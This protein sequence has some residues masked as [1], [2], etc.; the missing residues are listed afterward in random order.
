MK[1]IRAIIYPS[2]LTDEEWNEIQP[3]FKGMRHRKWSKRILVNAVFYVNKTGCQWRQLPKDF[4][5]YQ[6]VYSFFQR[7]CKS[8]LW[9]KILQYLVRRTREK[10]GRNTNPSY[11]IIDSQS[12]KSVYKGEERGYDGGEKKS[13]VVNGT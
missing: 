12:V 2:D 10:A 9:D 11:A 8:G 4:P 7:A 13:K 1:K 3:L 6:T 5:P